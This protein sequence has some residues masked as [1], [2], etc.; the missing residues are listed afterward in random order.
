MRILCWSFSISE[1]Y[2]THA[3][4]YTSDTMNIFQSI[5]NA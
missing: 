2:V 4:E 1:A 5:G 3:I